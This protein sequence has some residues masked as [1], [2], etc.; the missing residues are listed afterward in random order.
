MKK[1]R[2]S[3]AMVAPPFGD[4]GGPEVVTQNLT[5]ALLDMGIDVTLFAPADWNTRAKHVATLEKSIWNMNIQELAPKEFRKI[6][7]LSQEKVLEFQDDF[8]IIHLHSQRYAAGVCGQTETPCVISF[9]NRFPA[10]V[11]NGM[12]EAGLHTVALS[13]SQL[14]DLKASAVI[15]NGVP[16]KNIKYSFEKGS[17]LMFVG[18]LNDQKGIDTAIQIAIKAEKKLLIFGRIG[19]TE[20]RKIFFAENIEPFLSENIIY[21]GEVGHDEIYQYL[22]GASALLLPIRRPEVCPMVVAEALACGTP[23]IGT[24]IGPL[25]EL[26]GNEKIA[27]LSDDFSELVQAVKNTEIFDRQECRKYAEDNFDSTVMAK[28]YLELYYE[29]LDKN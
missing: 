27:F 5:D 3:I 8:D 19:N 24:M 23:I 4:T 20:E 15:H 16:T 10:D 18:R 29:I 17:Y 22:R 21:K 26:L 2:I 11:Y 9:H 12:V 14:G 6:K 1:N 13:K 25:P 7:I 28:R